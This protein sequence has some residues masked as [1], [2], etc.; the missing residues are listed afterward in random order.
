MDNQK[1]YLITVYSLMMLTVVSLSALGEQ[2][3]DV[4]ISLFTVCYFASTALFQPRKRGPDFVGVALFLVFSYIVAS[5][6]LE[7]IR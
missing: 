2:R 4:Y 6:I 1:K 5:K 7:I 3:F